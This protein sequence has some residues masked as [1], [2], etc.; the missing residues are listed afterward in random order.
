MAP[1]PGA[2]ATEAR[3]DGGILVCGIVVEE[4]SQVLSQPVGETFDFLLL[5]L[6]L[7]SAKMKD[8]LDYSSRDKLA[9][10]SGSHQR[11]PTVEPTP[12]GKVIRGANDLV[13]LEPHHYMEEAS[14]F[15]TRTPSWF[16]CEIE[17]VPLALES[18]VRLIFVESRPPKPYRPDVWRELARGK[19]LGEA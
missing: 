17:A 10:K 5:V 3:V 2:R 15:D 6:M 11:H 9:A 18:P 13:P 1:F 19:Y 14:P 7:V 4:A 16:Q 12:V 8:F